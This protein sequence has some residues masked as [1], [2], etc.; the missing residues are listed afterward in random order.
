MTSAKKIR[1]FLAETFVNKLPAKVAENLPN[2]HFPKSTFNSPWMIIPAPLMARLHRAIGWSAQFCGVWDNIVLAGHKIEGVSFD[3]TLHE[4]R[5]RTIANLEARPYLSRD[6]VKYHTCR[7]NLYVCVYYYFRWSTTSQSFKIFPHVLLYLVGTRSRAPGV[8][9]R[10]VAAKQ[11]QI[12][13]KK[14]FKEKF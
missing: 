13:S 12:L 14:V 11:P 7:S 4:E 1:S 8:P 10:R 3:A 5:H 9:A 2:N 6:T